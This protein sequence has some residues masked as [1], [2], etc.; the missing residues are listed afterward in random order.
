[1]RAS[2]K[3][4][5]AAGPNRETGISDLLTSRG[6]QERAREAGLG[7]EVIDRMGDIFLEKV[8]LVW[9]TI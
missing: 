5:F 4:A 1:M 8:R 2:R 7:R 6:A 9:T 3:A